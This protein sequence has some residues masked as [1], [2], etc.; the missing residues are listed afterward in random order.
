MATNRRKILFFAE[1]ATLAHV[2]RPYV[3]ASQLDGGPYEISFARPNSYAWLTENADFRVLD[4][5]CQPGETFVRR[6]ERGAPLYDLATLKHYVQQD[7]DLIKAEQ[8]DVVVGDFRLSLSVSARLAG[9]PYAT[10]CDAYWSPERPLTPPLPVLPFTPFLP[11]G[12]ASGLF[13]AISPLAFHLHAKPMEQLRAFHGMPGL[14]HDLRLT[15]TD[16]D[17]RL[18]ANHPALFPEIVPSAHADFLGP[19]AWSPTARDGLDLPQGDGPLAYVT[20]GSSGDPRILAALIPVLMEAGYRIAVATAGRP[21]PANLESGR[22]R[23]FDFLPGDQLCRLS[24]LVV[25]N[26]GSPTTNQALKHGVP[27]LGIARNMD[28]FLNMGAIE[29]YGAGLLVRADRATGRNLRQAVASLSMVSQFG[30]QAQSLVGEHTGVSLG[31]A[32]NRLCS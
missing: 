28:Q 14:R 12:L 2:A 26:G 13:R 30:Q 32:L 15:Y 25:C 4:L 3:L 27:V 24:Q 23:V 7:L 5:V 19:V 10:I 8:P 6:L 11:L 18:F 17:L 9:V 20:M 29:A 21:V 1:G 22:A 16:A 31:V